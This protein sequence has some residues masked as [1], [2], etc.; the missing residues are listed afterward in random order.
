VLEQ[1]YVRPDRAGGNELAFYFIIKRSRAVQGFVVIAAITNCKSA[2]RPLNP[3][4]LTLSVFAGLA[5]TAFLVIVAAALVYPPHQIYAE[6]FVVPIGALFA[7]S[8]IRANLP[9]APD[10]FG[11]LVHLS[12]E[13]TLTFFIL[14]EPP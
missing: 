11:E 10:G 4:V 13:P 8:S 5:G 1:S 7:F 2:A 14:Q 12:K 9:G 3:S 6:M